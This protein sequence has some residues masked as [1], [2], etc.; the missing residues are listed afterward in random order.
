ML[1]HK[2]HLPQLLSSD[3]QQEQQLI[4]A[5]G[6]QTGKNR[7]TKRSLDTSSHDDVSQLQHSASIT[8]NSPPHSSNESQQGTFGGV[9]G[10]SSSPP[11]KKSKLSHSPAPNLNAHA[12]SHPHNQPH[13]LHSLQQQQQQQDL[14][15]PLSAQQA[16]QIQQVCSCVYM[17]SCVL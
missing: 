2:Y 10:S 7:G 8:T 4:G 16:E 3:P 9:G 5:A 12:A 13:Q 6:A 1:S 15:R 14:L 17:C 11:H